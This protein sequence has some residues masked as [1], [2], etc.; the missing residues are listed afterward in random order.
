MNKVP[1][2]VYHIISNKNV[3][4]L[5]SYVNKLNHYYYCKI[6]NKKKNI[7]ARFVWKCHNKWLPQHIVVILDIYI[8][9]LRW[10][11]SSLSKQ[12]FEDT[13]GAITDKLYHIILYRVHIAWAGFELTTLVVLGFD[14]IGSYQ[15]NYHTITT[16]TDSIIYG[17]VLNYPNL[18]CYIFTFS[19]KSPITSTCFLI[20]ILLCAD[21]NSCITPK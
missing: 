3:T 20:V 6:P 15:S 13:K 10:T 8:Y 9:V 5:S 11:L 16:T 18:P 19:P 4:I 21:C 14:C 12:T 7:Y 1:N 2:R 17:D